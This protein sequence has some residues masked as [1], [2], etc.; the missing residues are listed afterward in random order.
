MC[1]PATAQV[2]FKPFVEFCAITSMS[3]DQSVAVGTYDDG[4]T[5]DVF[6]WTAAGGVQLIGLPNQAKYGDLSIS[7][8][9]KTIVG[10]VPD[11]G[12]I[13][14][15][16]IWQ[17]GKNWKILGEFSGAVS[18]EGGAVSV[19][20]GV[21]ADGSVIVGQAYVSLSKSV[22]FRWD[23]ANGM[24]N[25]GTFDEGVNSDSSS[26]AI[27]ADGGVV[28]GWDYK[29]G[30]IPPGPG[31]A[32]ENGRRGAIWLDGKERLLHPF[33]WAGEAWATNNNGSIIVGQFHPLDASETNGITGGAS[34]YL[35][36][37][38]NGNFEDLGA[39]QAPIGGGALGNYVSQPYAVSDDGSVIGGD[40]GVSQKFAMIWTRATGMMYVTDFLTMN[41]VT[42]Q[43]SWVTLS[44]TVYI[45]P[46]GRVVVGY[47]ALP[48]SGTS[49]FPV[50]RTWIM[51]LR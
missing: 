24:V 28:I 21:S 43:N 27:S 39:V 20:L 51:T 35:W 36:T 12:G 7:R 8:D 22:A 29:Q 25:L 34:T 18:G 10:T 9:G 33:G 14:H 40:T 3:A 23:P 5:H 46:D 11:S 13:Y 31:G 41:G 2:T 50:P 19:A 48:P 16:A 37:A 15:A 49:P 1:S 42:D 38:W 45:S 26:L 6:R 44:R 4:Y 30:F 17:G 47:G 32:A